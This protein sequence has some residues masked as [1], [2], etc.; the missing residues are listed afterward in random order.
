MLNQSDISEGYMCSYEVD[1]HTYIL[2]YMEY[3]AGL[4]QK[5]KQETNIKKKSGNSQEKP[6]WKLCGNPEFNDLLLVN[7]ANNV[8]RYKQRHIFQ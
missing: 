6:F 1:K 7:F 5:K 4:I 3:K 8:Q 2:I